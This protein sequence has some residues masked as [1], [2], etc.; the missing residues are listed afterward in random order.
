MLKRQIVALSHLTLGSTAGI[1]KTGHLVDDWG[2]L[3]GQSYRYRS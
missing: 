1:A 2:F 3:Y